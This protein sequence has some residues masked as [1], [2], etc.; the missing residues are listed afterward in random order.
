MATN[1]GHVHN[2]T[3][4][5]SSSSTSDE[6]EPEPERQSHD[7][8]I[9]T[10]VDP[11]TRRLYALAKGPGGFGMQISDDGCVTGYTGSNL[12]AEEQADSRRGRCCH[13][14]LSSTVI[15]CHPSGFPA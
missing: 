14:Q 4:S 11:H 3:N 15:D 7:T 12:P 13:S 8:G 5:S 9:R 6:A 2:A 10:M 1:S